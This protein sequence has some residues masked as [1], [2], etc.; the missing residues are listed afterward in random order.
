MKNNNLD[1]LIV[2]DE[3]LLALDLSMTLKGH[4]YNVIDYATTP[5]MAIEIM[6]KHKINLIL[7]DINL[8]TNIDGIDLYKR[9]KTDAKVIYLTAYHDEKTISKAVQTQPLG[10][11]IKPHNENELLALL[12]LA[13]VKLYSQNKTIYINDKYRFDVKEDTLYC[14]DSFIK[15]SAKELQLLKIL[16]KSQ[17]SVV[18]F[19]SLENEIWQ[20]SIPSPSSLRTLIYR[21]RGKIESDM[22][23]TELNHGV[24]LV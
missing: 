11:L 4:G 2:E 10:Y 18:S 5:M 12:K 22:I 16:I 3:S 6:D 21:L 23:E 13:E 24:K 15:L 17:G 19:K 9:F 8:Q 14:E 1:I 20:D 7:M